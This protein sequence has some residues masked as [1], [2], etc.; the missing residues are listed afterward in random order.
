[1]KGDFSRQTFNSKKHYRSVMMQQGRVQLDSDINEQQS[2]TQYF[3]ESQA[4]DIIGTSGVPRANYN[5]NGFKIEISDGGKDLA[6]SKG[7]IY[8]NGILCENDKDNVTLK[9]QPD[10]PGYSLPSQP[11]IYLIYLDVWHR[12][13]NALDDPDIREKALGGPDTT[14]R[15]KTIWMIKCIKVAERGTKTECKNFLS[16]W[17]PYPFQSGRL[18]AK[19]EELQ[20]DTGPCQLPKSSGYHSLENQL[21][22]IEI[23]R[24]G[25]HGQATFK[26]SREN[27]SVEASIKTVS[28]KTITLNNLRRDPALGFTNS[29]WVE[30]VTDKTE[31]A[32]EPD[33]QPSSLVKIASIHPSKP[34]VTIDTN[35]PQVSSDMHP[36]MRRWDHT[37]GDANGIPLNSVTWHDIEYGIKVN[38]SN[39][40][41]HSGDY[42]LIPARTAIN[43]ETGIIEWPLDETGTQPASELC[44]GVK[45]NYSP[46]ALADFDGTVFALL[47]DS[48][49]RQVFPPLTDITAADVKYLN[50]NCLPELA[51]AKTVQDAVDILCKNSKG[52]STFTVKPQKGWEKIFDYIGEGRDA[53]ICFQTGVYRIEDSIIIEKKGNISI[54]GCGAGT[55]IIASNSESAFKFKNC[56]EIHISNISVESGK[57]GATG[58]YEHLNGAVS[59]ED[60]TSVVIENTGLSCPSGPEQSC[61]CITVKNTD[62]FSDMASGKGIVRITGCN[63]AIGQSQS[64]I[65]LVNTG[66]AQVEGNILRHPETAKKPGFDEFAKNKVFRAKA[67]KLLISD[68][69]I[70]SDVSASDTRNAS[71]SYGGFKI[72]FNSDRSVAKSWQ[73]IINANPPEKVTNSGDLLLHAKK[74][75]EKTVIDKNYREASPLLVSLY[76]AV[77]KAEIPPAFQGVVVGGKTAKDIRIFNNTI[78]G[79][80]QGIH[81]GVS[82]CAPASAQPDKA[83]TITISGNNIETHLFSAKNERHGIFVGNCDSLLIESNYISLKR[84]PKK[85]LMIDGIRVYGHLGKFMII[86]QNHIVDFRT[87][88]LVKP[89]N[90]VS[91]PLWVVQYNM[92]NNSERQVVAPDSVKK[93]QNYA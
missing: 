53:Q 41:Y 26:W 22:R 83:G 92:L 9:K 6:V 40:T 55:Q 75:A 66:R 23:H 30:I 57:A 81:V 79:T 27:G 7:H 38:F 69:Y 34:E 5:G 80:L 82:H 20:Q 37:K 87:G 42:W 58:K 78:I 2:I 73:D 10:L 32:T 76:N 93:D 67:R 61:S 36:K 72:F 86:R 89:L 45:H 56:K 62:A 51:N 25:S 21:Y 44:H 17:A 90:N 48:D 46:L 15:L 50:T 11:G 29:Q 16:G 3:D 47:Q 65:L 70:G 68:A 19:T 14:T 49:C 74:I 18:T 59:F 63:L 28:S 85:K 35:Q 8:V 60:C 64:G 77:S 39:G 54:S 88:I 43:S 12:C 24:G 84:D 91:T 4:A 52:C 1:M 31:L 33:G 71:I 13:I